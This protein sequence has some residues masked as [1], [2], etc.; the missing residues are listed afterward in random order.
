MA[1]DSIPTDLAGLKE[2]LAVLDL[3]TEKVPTLEG[4]RKAYRAKL[5]LHPDKQKG[6]EFEDHFKCITQAF[7]LISLFLADYGV[8]N[9]ASEDSTNKE[10]DKILLSMLQKENRLSLNKLSVTLSI[11]KGDGEIWLSM[12]EKKL[13]TKRQSLSDKVGFMVK[14]DSVNLPYTGGVEVK[15]CV[16]VWPNPSG[17]PKMVIEGKGYWPFVMCVVPSLIKKVKEIKN[18]HL[19]CPNGSPSP[20]S[21]LPPSATPSLA[22]PAGAAAEAQS[23]DKLPPP[24]PPGL[25]TEPKM[26]EII[27][28]LE[29]SIVDIASSLNQRQEALEKN[30]VNLAEAVKANPNRK[31]LLDLGESINNLSNTVTGAVTKINDSCKAVSEV[32]VKLNDNELQELSTKIVEKTVPAI[33]DGIVQLGE[34]VDHLVLESKKVEQ[35]VS[36]CVLEQEEL[37]SNLAG[38][39][40]LVKTLQGILDDPSVKITV[41]NK[42]SPTHSENSQEQLTDNPRRRIGCVFTSSIGKNTPVEKLQSDLNSDI[43]IHA[44]Y[45]IENNKDLTEPG[46]YLALKVNEVMNK[47]VDFVIIQVGSNE[48]SALDLKENKNTIFEKIQQDCDKIINLAQHMVREYEV[49]VFISEKPPRYDNKSLEQG[50]IL[51]GLNNTS[52]SILHMRSHLLERVWIIKQSMLESKS[53]RVRGERFMPDGLHLTEKGLSLLNTNWVD[54]IKRVYTDLQQ[55]LPEQPHQGGGRGGGGGQ[56]GGCGG[57]RGGG[58]EYNSGGGNFRGRRG[59]GGG[60]QPQGQTQSYDGSRG[61]GGGGGQGEYRQ[62]GRGY[63]DDNQWGGYSN[64]RSYNGGDG[65]EEIIT[66][67]RGRSQVLR[68]LVCNYN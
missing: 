24:I 15:V 52:N 59:G 55:P 56:V 35:C 39:P 18:N 47:E 43:R 27:A 32:T 4:A 62:Q 26:S 28:K 16:R 6:D 46:A 30:V 17:S 25:N 21:Q 9:A 66:E 33:S 51:E 29:A 1:D 19:T 5:H 53:D 49:D 36:K 3:T 38:L 50:G 40:K 45:F 31:Q 67:G 2:Y 20:T 42:T 34:K 54:S 7:R 41:K 68:K 13:E 64:R 60:Y 23:A 57:F 37:K 61:G 22:A 11:E 44:T 8:H 12:L 48:M 14:S 63:R 58:Q 65:I 10:E